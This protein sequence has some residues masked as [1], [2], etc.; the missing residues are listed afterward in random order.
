MC[1]LKFGILIRQ[2]HR[3]LGTTE[4]ISVKRTLNEVLGLRT[5]DEMIYSVYGEKVE[6]LTRA[7]FAYTV[8]YSTIFLTYQCTAGVIC[9]IMHSYH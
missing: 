7:G 9:I 5:L 6:G 2:P 8:W 1:P 4:K 3:G